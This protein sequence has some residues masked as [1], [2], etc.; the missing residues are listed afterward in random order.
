MRVWG[1]E[2]GAEKR[3]HTYVTSVSF[4]GDGKQVVSGSRDRR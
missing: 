1:V 2:A 4:S 3:G